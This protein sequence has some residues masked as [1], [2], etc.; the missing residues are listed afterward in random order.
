MFIE[1]KAHKPGVN[2]YFVSEY[3]DVY[4]LTSSKFLKKK[5]D[6]DGY[7]E[8]A[9]ALGKSKKRFVRGHRLVLEVFEG[10]SSLPMVNHIDGNKQNNHVS[11]LEW[12]TQSHNELH[13]RKYLGKNSFGLKS[14]RKKINYEIA[15]EIRKG[16]ASGFSKQ[17]LASKYNISIAQITRVIKG[18]VWK[19]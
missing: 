11:N 7:V 2:K 9:L 8:F 4:S 16:H 1:Y 5:L 12:C 14:S 3:G 10:P 17:H 13:A 19:L 6:K 18:E 15:E